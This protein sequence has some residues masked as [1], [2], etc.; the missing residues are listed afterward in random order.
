MIRGDCLEVLKTL[1]SNSVDSLITDHQKDRAYIEMMNK[2]TD[3]L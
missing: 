1:E 3:N 2:E